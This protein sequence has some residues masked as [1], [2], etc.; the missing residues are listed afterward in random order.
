[1][2]GSSALLAGWDARAWLGECHL[3]G[4]LGIGKICAVRAVAILASAT[5]VSLKKL[6]PLHP[7]IDPEAKE[8]FVSSYISR[9]FKQAANAEPWN[10]S[11]YV[12]LIALGVL[13][14]LRVYTSWATWGNLSIDCGR[15]MYVPAILEQ[16]KTLYKDVWFAYMPA[17]PYLN[18]ALYRIFGNS[19][20]TLYWAGSLAA[21]GTAVVL[22][23]TGKKLGSWI[24]GWGAGAVVL[25]Q[26]FHSWH[27]CFPLPYSFSS[28]YGC[29]CACLFLWALVHVFDPSSR[30]WL[31]SAGLLA[32]VA[33]LLKLEFGLAC[34][35]ALVLVLSLRALQ[36]KSARVLWVD[37]AIV[38]P[39]ILLV[40]SVIVWMVSLG[41]FQFITQEN[42]ASTWPQSY[43][44]KT[45][46][47]MWLQHT[48]LAL[49]AAALQAAA[50]RGLFSLGVLVEVCLLLWWKRR[51]LLSNLIRVAVFLALVP[52]IWLALHWRPF[53]ILAAILFPRD[54]VFYVGLAGLLCLALGWRQR[55]AAN[56]AVVV[57]LLFSCLL[58]FRV[59]LRNT[60]GGY[61]IYYNGPAILVFLLL[62]KALLPSGKRGKSILAQPETLVCLACVGIAA[63]YSLNYRADTSDLVELRTERGMIRVPRQVASNYEAGIRLMKESARNGEAVLSVP[64]DV[65]LYFLSGTVCPT[66]LYSFIP[67]I[68]APGAVTEETI[69]EIEQGNVKYL[70]WSNRNYSDYGVPRF[71]EDYAPELGNYLKAHYRNKGPLVPNSDLDWETRFDLWQRIP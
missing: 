54:M 40:L 28:V 68:I 11:S 61:A 38:S 69:R 64:E 9:L 18:A 4:T 44:L 16:G 24:C 65:S 14:C 17:A 42:L 41:G 26:S 31:F 55:P 13:W 59:L 35:V 21:L 58:G 20:T 43:F 51:D 56:S 33:F 32:G 1:M 19:L 27:F 37:L 2:F 45:Y 5:M 71:A 67:G 36:Q 29:L 52:Y 47:K 49:N 6:N 34:Y 23:L 63:F 48:G 57:A 62:V 7:G 22:F 50:I 46:G 39:G 66:R 53:S 60:P 10:R 25:F 30:K 70:L 3:M 12:G 15:E 8:G